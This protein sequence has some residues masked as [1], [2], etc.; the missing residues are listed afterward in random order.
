MYVC[1]FLGRWQEMFEEECVMDCFPFLILPNAI[2]LL[3]YDI[4]PDSSGGKKSA[5]N[6]R[7]SV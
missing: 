5:C 7:T 3:L 4:F 6:A 1:T 2:T